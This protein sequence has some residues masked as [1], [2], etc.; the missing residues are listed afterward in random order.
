MRPETPTLSTSIRILLVDDCEPWRQSVRSIL[1]KCEELHVVGDAADGL[2]AVQKAQRLQPDVIL[3]D[4]GLPNV[5][6][7]EAASRIAQIAPSTKILFLTQNTDVDVLQAALSN[8]AQGYVLKVDAGCDLMP[9]IKAVLRGER[10][11]SSRLKN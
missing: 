2:E 10:F 7:I 1:M 5:N 3:L 8:W 4:I 11:V 6:G 9:A